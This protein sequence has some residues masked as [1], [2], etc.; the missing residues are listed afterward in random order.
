MAS[1]ATLGALGPKA[2][3]NTLT[4][5]AQEQAAIAA[6]DGGG[7]VVV[8]RDSAAHPDDIY[9]QRYDDFGHPIGGNILIDNAGLVHTEPDVAALPGGGFVV[10]WTLIEDGLGQVVTRVFNGSDAPVTSITD[11]NASADFYEDHAQI[12]TL[13]DSSGGSDVARGFLVTWTS[14]VGS[15]TGIHARHFNASGTP[16]GATFD[17]S[18]TTPSAIK[19]YA[20]TPLTDGGYFVT[21]HHVA[22][23]QGMN[24]AYGQMFTASGNAV[25]TQLD[26]SAGDTSRAPDVAEL[27][28]GT[29]VLVRERDSAHGSHDIEVTHLNDT[30]QVLSTQVFNSTNPA[31]QSAR[32]TRPKVA[33]LSTGEFVVAWEQD[34][35]TGSSGRLVAQVFDGSAQPIDDLLVLNAGLLEAFGLEAL[36][37]G[38][39]AVTWTAYDSESR[40]DVYVQVFGENHLPE[41]QPEIIGTAVEGASLGA[42]VGALVDADGITT[43][44]GDIFATASYVWLRDGE[45]IMGATGQSYTLTQAD[46]DHQISVRV[47]YEDDGR[48]TE[49]VTSAASD[50]VTNTSNP[51]TGTAVITGLA[52]QGQTLIGSTEDSADLDGLGAPIHVWLRDGVVI[53]GAQGASYTLTQADVGHQITYSYRFTDGEGSEEALTSAATTPILNINDGPEGPLVV[54]GPAD[55]GATVFADESGL[56]DPDGPEVLSFAYQWYRDEEEIAGATDREFDLTATDAGAQMSVRVF[57]TDVDGNAETALSEVSAPVNILPTGTINVTGTPE[58]DVWLTADTGA[59]ADANGVVSGF[60]YQWLRAGEVI[61]GATEASYQL[62][63]EDVGEQVSVRVSYTDGI[64]TLEQVTSAASGVVTNIDDGPSDAGR[65][66]GSPR[67]GATLSI[68]DPTDPDGTGG[69]FSYQ[70]TRDGVDIS[71]ATGA[72]YTVTHDDEGQR[73]GVRIDWVDD[74]GGTGEVVLSSFVD[75]YVYA[76]LAPMDDQ[77]RVDTYTRADNA[78]PVVSQLTSGGYVVIWE[79]SENPGGPNG[80]DVTAGIAGQVFDGL[81]NPVGTEFQAN[82]THSGVAEVAPDVTHL[83][84]GGFFVVYLGASGGQDMI[85]GQRFDAEGTALGP[86]VVIDTLAQ[87]ASAVE[88]RVATLADGRV[89]VAYAPDETSD[90]SL[91][92]YDP[93]T[94]DAIAL[95]SVT[96]PDPT[97]SI[98]SPAITASA[99]GGALL[100]WHSSSNLDGAPGAVWVQSLAADLT[101]FGP[102]IEVETM[103]PDE[104]SNPE[105]TELAGG[106][107]VV[108]WQAEAIS[109]S[110]IYARIYDADNSALT[111]K[112]H[113]STPEWENTDAD[114]IA[115]PDGGFVIAWTHADSAYPYEPGLYLQ[116]FNGAGARDGEVIMVNDTDHYGTDSFAVEGAPDLELLDDGS[117]VVTWRYSR[118]SDGGGEVHSRRFGPWSDNEDP[119]GSL[120]VDGLAVEGQTLAAM[121]DGLDDP[122]GLGTLSY[123]WYA[124]GAAIVGATGASFTLTNGEVGRAVSVHLSYVDGAGVPEVLRSAATLDVANVNDPASGLVSLSG[125]AIT[126]QTLVAQHS[127]LADADGL[128]ASGSFTYVWYRDGKEIKRGAAIAHSLSDADIGKQIHVD[129]LFEDLHGTVETLHSGFSDPVVSAA[130]SGGSNTAPSGHPTITGTGAVGQKLRVDLS[131][132]GDANGLSASP[133]KFKYKWKRDGAV[134]KGE[135]GASYTPTEDDLGAR[136][137]VVVRYKDGSGTKEIIAS[138]VVHIVAPGIEASGASGKKVIKGGKGDDVLEGRSQDDKFAGKAGTDTAVLDSGADITLDLGKKGAQTTGEGR[139]TFKSIENVRTG[140]GDDVITGSKSANLLETGAGDDLID[141]GKGKDRIAAGA[142]DDVINGGKGKDWA[143]FGPGGVSVDLS[144]ADAQD[145]GEGRDQLISIENLRGGSGDDDLR[146][147]A[148][149]NKLEGGEGDDILFG[150]EGRDQFIFSGLFGHDEITDFDSVERGDRLIFDGVTREGLMI[151]STED[152]I[153]ILDTSTNSTLLLGNVALADFNEAWHLVII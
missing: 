85:W 108:T 3:V 145:T 27:S 67:V 41:G 119:S 92:A 46:V 141:G 73:L 102:L 72:S 100:A 54:G 22:N 86:E 14:G 23:A 10:A 105:V 97:S 101:T 114:I 124:D 60:S 95:G 149:A 62:T 132:I 35:F 42:V 151:T 50:L 150:G 113:V 71:G 135:K 26:L 99:D 53:V 116:R 140:A 68:E 78:N 65:I 2:L 18:I 43:L 29:L 126:G 103:L 8:F 45:E 96:A 4:N 89:L 137:S 110:E 91:A 7:F 120:E 133:S 129:I 9:A 138:D 153:F 134:I 34:V 37:G 19:D 56:Y 87:S 122:D 5:A 44:P 25:G 74:Y 83:E 121:L 69:G 40:D 30:G 47:T 112:I 36:A 24:P 111:A 136:I 98:H 152:G 48:S 139:D 70:W 20:I 84:D 11:V 94:G 64:G 109:G 147:N 106:G 51:A 17:I 144:L 104:V 59:L 77:T 125:N 82:G 63:Q 143:L 117:L 33:L 115:L 16:S 66:I 15:F 127:G 38:R 12:V 93:D 128:P 21:W 79:A 76:G 28:D 1:S 88:L 146:G 31:G 61:S 39:F 148:K 131:D 13:T 55:V 49:V 80:D 90:L 142:G 52:E 123:Q 58:E 75:S 57:Y 118:L 81:G 130:Y 32:D 107:W 6:L